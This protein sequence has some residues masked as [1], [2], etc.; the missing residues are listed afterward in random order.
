MTSTPTPQPHAIRLGS[1]TP[2]VLV[3]GN[4]VDHRIMLELD[5]AFAA[6]EQWERIY[7][8]LPGFGGTPALDAPGGLPEVADWLDHTVGELVGDKPFAVVGASLG[9][10]LA[11]DL[12]A[13]RID[14]CLGFALLAPVVDS[15]R[16]NRTVPPASVLVTDAELLA[17][18]DAQDATDYAELAV[19]QSPDNWERFNRALI[20]GIRAADPRAMDQLAANYA[21]P[22]LPD[23]ALAGFPRPVLIATG[24]QDHVVGFEDQWALAQRFPRATYAMI[25]AAGH[26]LHIDQPDAVRALLQHWAL[27]VEE[28]VT[29]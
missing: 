14:Q 15:V 9:A 1:G 27:A 13:R 10:L 11:R 24:K 18:L 5:D 22:A 7:L 3:H 19:I 26:N 16:A 12:V 6:A 8:D 23:D 29:P 28:H 4:G 21:L 2:I 25:D 17:S 20:P